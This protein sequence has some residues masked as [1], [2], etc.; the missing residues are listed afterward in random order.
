M[1]NLRPV[2]FTILFI[3]SI[4]TFAQEQREGYFN[5]TKLGA[6]SVLSEE[7]GGIVISTVNGWHF[8]EHLSAGIGIAAQGIGMF[9]RS[10]LFLHM[11]H[12]FLKKLSHLHTCMGMWGTH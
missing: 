1:R 6:I 10:T 11:L 2:L 9:L 5:N 8:T 7:Y 4:H 3:S 12:I